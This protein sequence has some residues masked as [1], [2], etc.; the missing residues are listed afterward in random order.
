[1]KQYLE[2]G[3]RILDEGERVP[4]RAVLPSTGKNVHALSLFG[5]RAVYDLREGF[6]AVTT[7]KLAFK[8]VVAELLWFLKGTQDTDYLKE[9]GAENIWKP[10][11]F[12]DGRSV[13]PSYGNSWRSWPDSYSMSV[14]GEPDKTI[15]QIAN[16]VRDIKAAVVDRTAS[17]SRRLIVAAWNPAAVP[18]VKLPPCHAWFQCN[19]SKTDPPPNFAG[20]LDLQM[21]QRSC[22]YFLGVPFNIASYAL[23]LTMLA[24]V[25]GLKPRYFKHVYGDVHVYENHVEQ[26]REQISR[27]PKPMPSLLIDTSVRGIDGFLPTSFELKDYDPWPTLK[28]EVAV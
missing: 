8:M 26:M 11:T 9:L 5:E 10:W 6:P 3:R 28:G 18:H 23:L 14:D 17:V 15:D 19:V 13:G 1:M 2:L 25:T 4:T 24:Q 16:L 22:D 20:W 21:Y 27:A 12:E 7:K